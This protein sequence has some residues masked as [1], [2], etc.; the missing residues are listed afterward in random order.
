MTQ[1]LQG[2]PSP[3]AIAFTGLQK[4]LLPLAPLGLEGKVMAPNDG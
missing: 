1:L 3:L 4:Q 2:S